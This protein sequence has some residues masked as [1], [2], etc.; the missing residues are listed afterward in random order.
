MK[1]KFATL[2]LF[3]LLVMPACYDVEEPLGS[4]N[5]ASVK[6]ELAGH[7]KKVT[8]GVSRPAEMEIT[9]LSETEYEIKYNDAGVSEYHLRAFI[10]DLNGLPIVNVQDFEKKDS[11]YSI[12]SYKFQNGSEHSEDI[13]TAKMLRIDSPRFES[14][15]D[16][17]S[18]LIRHKN[19]PQIL[20]ESEI[21]FTR[22]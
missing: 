3:L 11:N 8:N 16:L 5:E 21:K 15:S 19:H 9:L 6:T 4:A 10:V 18:Y 12:F 17:K 20:F 1:V 2:F 14:S 7:W 22:K 13:L